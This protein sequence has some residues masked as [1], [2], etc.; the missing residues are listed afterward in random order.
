MSPRTTASLALIST[1]LS[2][3]TAIAVG[4]AH[5]SD[6][7]IESSVKDSY[8]Y[9]NTLKD[10]K[11]KV[12]SVDGA[13]TLT[14]TVAA[15]HHKALANDAAAAQHGVKS[16]DNTLQVDAAAPEP[17]SD[18]WLAAKVKAMLLFHRSVSAVKTEV[19]AESGVVT[20][21]GTAEN[22]AQ[23]DLT[24]EYAL[25]VEGVTGINNNITL[26]GEPK[27]ERRLEEKLDDSSITAQVKLTLLFHRSTSAFNTHVETRR[28]VVTLSGTAKSAAEK[29]LAEKIVSDVKG[30]RNVTNRIE[31]IKA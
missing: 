17:K 16:V 5:T 14:G 7:K 13:V 19:A 24:G 2:V 8:V 21:T 18:A 29:D 15:D 11:I 22:Q 4:A 26:A 12:R 30:V 27:K 23:K 28:G 6:A 10:D 9:K 25:D 31:V 1:V 20:L 3:F